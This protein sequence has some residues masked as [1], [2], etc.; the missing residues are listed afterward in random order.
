MRVV[1]VCMSALHHKI[2]PDFYEYIIPEQ[3]L[4]IQNVYNIFE[5]MFKPCLK[6]CLPVFEKHASIMCDKIFI[7]FMKTLFLPV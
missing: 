6:T 1:Y 2:L 5:E 4:K 3:F 7:S